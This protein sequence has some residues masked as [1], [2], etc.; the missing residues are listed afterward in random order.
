VAGTAEGEG[1]SEAPPSPTPYL[2]SI[3]HIPAFSYLFIKHNWCH[4]QSVVSARS[5]L[6]LRAL[7]LTLFIGGILRKVL[8]GLSNR[9]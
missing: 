3:E 8:T 9:P 5:A 1:P 4:T 7:F 2:T 6:Y